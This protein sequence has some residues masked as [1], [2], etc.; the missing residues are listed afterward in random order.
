[1]RG[2]CFKVKEGDK[3]GLVGASGCG[4]STIL[5]LLLGF[6]HCQEGEILVDNERIEDYDVH[7][8]RRNLA[9]VS[10]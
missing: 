10:Q 7:C 6:Y 3:V 9:T 5:K 8:L 2:L 1:M 4:K